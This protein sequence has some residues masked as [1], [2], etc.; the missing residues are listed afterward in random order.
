[1]DELSTNAGMECN[2]SP[3]TN[4]GAS[5]PPDWMVSREEIE[6]STY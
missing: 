2:R 3:K 4:R 6:P 1:M 5:P